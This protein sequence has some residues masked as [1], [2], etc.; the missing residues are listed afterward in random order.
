M[1]WNWPTWHDVRFALVLVLVF[2]VLVFLAGGGGSYLGEKWSQLWGAK[3]NG[4]SSSPSPT[5]VTR[6]TPRPTPIQAKVKKLADVAQD[7]K[8]YVRKNAILCNPEG[9]W[10]EKNEVGYNEPV[11]GYGSPI[12][13]T[14]PTYW[15]ADGKERR[16][17]F[18]K[19][20]KK[21]TSKT[22][23]RVAC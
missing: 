23:F 11:A 10:V 7:T 12:R 3:T 17:D 5:E 1:K 2:S 15:M 8:L 13:R 21:F 14:G 19:T 9:C 18:Q 16:P 4:S 20:E 6:F 22:H